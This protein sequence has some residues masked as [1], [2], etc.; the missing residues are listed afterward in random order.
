MGVSGQL[1]VPLALRLNR[2]LGESQS[3]SG[4]CGGE[5][6]LLPLSG[7]ETRFLGLPI[8]SQVATLTRLFLLLYNNYF[9]VNLF[10]NLAS[11]L[12]FR[13]GW[14]CGNPTDVPSGVTPEFRQNSTRLYVATS[15]KIAFFI[16]IVIYQ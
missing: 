8:R 9:I 3:R 15:Q 13:G 10:D 6:N 7:I 4:Q 11:N 12:Y 5:K 14:H 16:Q 2:S 1:H